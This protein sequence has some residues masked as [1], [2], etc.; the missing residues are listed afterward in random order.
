[1]LRRHNNYQ[2]TGSCNCYFALYFANTL[3]GTYGHFSGISFTKKIK[4]SYVLTN[5]APEAL[6]VIECAPQ[7]CNTLSSRCLRAP[8]LHKYVKGISGC[9][10]LETVAV[11]FLRLS[12]AATK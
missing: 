9:A 10:R 1:M 12:Y 11:F 3:Y 7:C 8:A 5:F 4:F 2:I 6:Y